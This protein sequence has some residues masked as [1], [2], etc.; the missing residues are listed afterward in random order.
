MINVHAIALSNVRFGGAESD[1]INL[2]VAGN[3][4]VF[5]EGGRRGDGITD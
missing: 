3:A 2:N 4:R 5:F 1:V